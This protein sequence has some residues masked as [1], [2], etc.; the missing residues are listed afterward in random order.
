MNG[1]NGSMTGGVGYAQLPKFN[2]G[3][4][5]N[6]R[7]DKINIYGSYNYQYRESFER[8]SLNRIVNSDSAQLFDQNTY[9]ER[10]FQN[11]IYKVGADYFL[12]KR[13]TVGFLIN[14]YSSLL[15]RDGISRTNI[16]PEGESADY[17]LSTWTMNRDRYNSMSYNLNYAGV[18]DTNG[19][20]LSIDADMGTFKSNGTLKLND[21]LLDIHT[22]KIIDANAIKNESVT[23]IKIKSIKSDYT[24][25]LGKSSKAEMG[26][27]VSSVST[28]NTLLYDS[29]LNNVYV[30][31]KSQS[32]EFN[33]TETIVA[34]YGILSKTLKK[35]AVQLGVRAENTSSVG[36]SIALDSTVKR[37]YLNFFPSLLI[38]HSF[39]ENH[40]IDLSYS[41]RIDRPAYQSL[42]PILFFLD[43][44]T[45]IIGNPFLKP[46]YTNAIE[47]SY[48]FHQ[49]Y[50]A[51]IGYS[52]TNQV[53]LEFIEQN[54]KTKITTSTKKNLN[55]Q[56]NYMLSF[57]IPVAIT[58][59]W[60]CSNNLSV[61]YSEFQIKDNTTNYTN[62]IVGFNLRTMHSFSL[63]GEF[64]FQISGFYNSPFV[65]G[66]FK[67]KEQY[68]V[69]L[70]LQKS[71]WNRRINATLN[72]SDI[73][74]NNRFYGGANYNNI[75]IAIHNR[76]ETRIVT[77]TL[78]YRFGSNEIKLARERRAATEEEQKRIRAN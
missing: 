33:Y 39:D 77:L 41:R 52:R 3:L 12:S 69:D 15:D 51:S 67:G 2:G 5:L 45:Y 25:P 24:L 66:V 16:G 23:D 26:V 22:Q 13:H 27:K 6:Y 31:S 74:K 20:E 57:S 37:N 56:N 7:V 48:S 10:V 11:H 40:K 65:A 1:L 4:N 29:L 35:T 43:K 14:G 50:I 19:M 70:G 32:D 36:K 9:A 76:Y 71:F 46:Q 17:L 60:S 42:N 54:D 61:N 55:N 47:A 68:I 21:N 53:I 58:S 30:P 44:Y 8:R 73:F 49:K 38:S 64:K 28:S 78:S 63:P 18:L 72:L 62:S 59:W 75:N 34:G